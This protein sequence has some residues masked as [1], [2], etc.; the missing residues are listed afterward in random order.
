MV[1]VMFAGGLIEECSADDVIERPEHI[2]HEIPSPM[3]PT[4]TFIRIGDSATT[5][6]A[7][8]SSLGI[9]SHQGTYK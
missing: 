4:R 1:F 2:H 8:S 3:N 5:N 6:A 9:L 7:T